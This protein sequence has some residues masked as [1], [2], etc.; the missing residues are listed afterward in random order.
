MKM[1]RSSRLTFRSRQILRVV[2]GLLTIIVFLPGI[3]KS[4]PAL[5]NYQIDREDNLTVQIDDLYQKFTDFSWIAYAP[6]H[7]DP[8]V[9]SMPAEQ[10]ISDDLQMLFDVGF[11]G[12]VT[13]GSEG[14]MA[15]IPRLARGVGFQGVVMGI[16]TPGSEAETAA[17]VAAVDYV[18]GYVVGNEGL[19][20]DR[21]DFATLEA[22]MADL[23]AQTGKPV[24]TTEVQPLYEKDV[25]NGVLDVGDWVFPNIHPFWAH[26]TDPADA[27]QWTKIQ[28][29]NLLDAVGAERPV[30][31]KEVGLPTAGAE[32]TSELR[33]AEYYFR[34]KETPVVFVYFEAFD[35]PWKVEGGGVGAHWGLFLNDRSPKAG[36]EEL[37]SGSRP[38]VYIYSDA[39]SSDNRFYP[40]GFMGC[41]YNLHMEEGYSENPHSGSTAIQID[42]KY[43]G[44]T[45]GWGGIYWWTPASCNWQQMPCGIDL[46]GWTKLTFWARGEQGN[47]Y[48]EFKV[49]GLCNAG[50]TLCDS[51]NPAISTG[52][53]SLSNVWTQYTIY[54]DNADL[55]RIGGGFV[56]VTN[57][58]KDITIYLDD[59][60]FE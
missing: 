37:F 51:L 60:R 26:V 59:I 40:S 12:V 44:C 38:P 19:Y 32:S 25:E 30:V 1:R 7:Y 31:F 58:R 23:K 10:D 57:D 17:A 21:Y 28:Y 22:A 33:Q 15:E 48:V 34:L 29:E 49:G 53:I 35:Q 54:L 4:V 18:D 55:S 42:Y 46:S 6:T 24:T 2:F 11:R 14:T 13:Y 52:L 5:A 45:E 47:E 9:G 50:Q 27:A 39:Q 43:Y 41:Y 8:T 36:I 3:P 56:F 16:W 20:N